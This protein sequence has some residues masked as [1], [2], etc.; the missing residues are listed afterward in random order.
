MNLTAFSAWI[1]TTWLH[2]W[3]VQNQ[4]VFTAAETLHFMGLTVLAG[5][6]LVIDLRGLGFLKRMPFLELHKLVP[7]AIGAFVLQLLTGVT[8]IASSPGHYFHDLSFQVKMLLIP[9]A[10]VNAL[11]FE[12]FVFRPMLAGV[13]GVEQRAVTKITSGLSIVIWA[14]VL[15]CGRLIPY[16]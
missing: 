8:F 5:S 14:L 9:V 13:Q 15:I 10:G 7:F 12:F 1:E 6:L 4:L 2:D 11:V 16:I 3:V